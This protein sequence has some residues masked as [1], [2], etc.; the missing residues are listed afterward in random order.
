MIIIVVAYLRVSSLEQNLSLQRT[1]VEPYKPEK[2]FEE[3][4]S[5]KNMERPQLQEM[6]SFIRAGDQIVVY[7]LSRISRSLKDMLEL[8]D[9]ILEKGCTLTTISENLTISKQDKMAKFLCSIIGICAELER[10]QIRERQALG[11]IEAKKRGVYKGRKPIEVSDFGQ[12]YEDYMSRRIT[13]G[14]LAKKLHISRPTLNKLFD[15]YE[16]SQS[17]KN[18]V[19]PTQTAVS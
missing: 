11:I 8:F 5:G 16:K 4:I 13:K 1:S 2:I 10:D 18:P 17:A 6:L 12:Y 9:I 15:E 14:Q 19:I 3:K 7:S